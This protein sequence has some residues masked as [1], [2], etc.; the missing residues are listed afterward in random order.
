MAR[1]LT[2]S[3]CSRQ[4]FRPTP[5]RAARPF[6]ARLPGYAPTPLRLL[7]SLA[8]ELGVGELRLKDESDRLGLP[9]FK[10][11][12]ASWATVLIL[13]RALGEELRGLDLDALRARLE[14]L[15]PARLVAATDGN[16]GRAVARMASLLG[17]GAKVFVPVGTDA[18]RSAAIEGE[19]AEVVEAGASYER[20]L[21]YAVEAATEPRSFLVQDV[22]WEGF[23]EVP[24][25]IVEG[26]ATMFWELEEQTAAARL[27]PPDV[28]FVPIGAGTLA[29]AVINHF[30][31]EGA[32]PVH[33]VAVEPASAACAMAAFE[34]GGVIEIECSHASTMV[35][36]NCGRIATTAWPLLERG[37]DATVA[38]DD[39]VCGEALR[40]LA[41][42]DVPVGECG[43]S[44]LGALLALLRDDEAAALRDRLGLGGDARILLLATEGVTNP[45]SYARWTS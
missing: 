6:H 19:G 37:L 35:G 7:D 21:E 26:Y 36:L 16:H 22:S 40:L 5:S 33:I 38:I 42:H 39:D 45:E 2:N 8:S 29:S 14:P 3:A 27:E 44:G 28:V 12:G 13:E 30:R 1:F 24:T 34:H 43:A 41:K 11:L 15:R 23:E 18:P 32:P 17:L 9:A 20:T 10:F 4:S 31:R 25:W